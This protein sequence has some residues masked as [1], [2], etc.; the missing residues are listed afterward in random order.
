MVSPRVRKPVRHLWRNPEIGLTCLARFQR[1]MQ[2]QNIHISTQELGEIL[3]S[4][5]SH[6]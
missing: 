6:T 3:A 1:K 2:A 5:P 4:E